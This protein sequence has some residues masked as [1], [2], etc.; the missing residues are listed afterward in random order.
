MTVL[1]AA[2]AATLSSAVAAFA[3]AVSRIVLFDAFGEVFRAEPTQTNVLTPTK[4]ERVFYITE[5]EAVTV[6][7]RMALMTGNGVDLIPADKQLFAGWTAYN[8]AVV[9]LTQGQSV[10]EW[11]AAD[12]TRI[13]ISGGTEVLKCY[14]GCGF[15]DKKEWDRATLFVKNQGFE[16]VIISQNIGGPA[17]AVTVQPGETLQI[18]S[19]AENPYDSGLAERQLRIETMAAADTVDIIAW[20][21]WLEIGAEL[22]SSDCNI[23][24]VTDP[25][26]LQVRWTTE[27]V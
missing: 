11:G 6:V 8:G 20:R 14:V 3:D 5:L 21:P 12:A 26:S 10:P 24:K 18:V 1:A 15:A 4:T 16:A 25:Y 19:T 27:V 17:S 23:D 7:T 9:T 22:C 2:T 13:Q